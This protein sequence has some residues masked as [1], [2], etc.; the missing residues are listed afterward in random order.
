MRPRTLRLC[1]FASSRILLLT[2]LALPAV[3]QSRQAPKEL[4]I[5]NATILT[6]SRGTIEGGS[7][8][9]RDGKI[10]EVGRNVR[11]GAGATVID[12]TGKFVT[13]GIVD[14]HSH[15]AID[16]SVNE[17]S[18]SVTSMTRV[19]DVI[20]PDDR[21][22]LIGLSGGVTTSNLLHGSANAIGGQN[23]VI[24]MRWGKPADALLFEGAPPGIKF[25]LGENP[26]RSNFRLDPPRYPRT[27][28]GVED[29]IRDA[30]TR[31]RNYKAEWQ[32]YRAA[33]ESGDKA[34]LPPRRDLE[35]EP[36]VEV[37]DGRR[38]VHA[39]CYRADEILMLLRVAREFN[40]R[41][42]TL[43]HVL[44]G[45]KVAKEIAAAGTG[46][47][48]FAD[49]W[50]YKMEAYDAIPHNA[51]LMHKAGVLTSIN[52]DDGERQRRLN[53]DAARAVRYGGVSEEDALRM[54][55]LFPARQLGID[56][57][58]GS[59]DVGK[60]ADLVVWSAPP[61][62]SYAVAEKVFVDGEQY[63]DR[64]TMLR[65]A[66]QALR[67]AERLHAEESKQARP[68]EGRPARNAARGGTR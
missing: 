38:L 40:F 39:H 8:L 20:D 64:E 31:A 51:A 68:T 53:T 15:I 54:I 46:A 58:V 24:K 26:K 60:H 52:S 47:S 63:F 66:D 59:I 28:M 56:R 25:A 14:C 49:N 7:I 29:V 36:L 1:A 2:L 34:A 13:P 9:V 27:R 21:A 45:Y 35:L 32:R 41:I 67:E 48:T 65:E 61:L 6:A 33:V 10:A 22:I 17:G 3:A 16:G 12:A 18:L 30:F 5:R 23:A 62:S 55:T 4:V 50:A 57:W 43:Q 44:E 42:A 11:A 19:A 37:L